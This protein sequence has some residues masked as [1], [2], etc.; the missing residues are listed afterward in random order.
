MRG[1]TQ[2]K[3]GFMS[4]NRSSWLLGSVLAGVMLVPACESMPDCGEVAAD[5]ANQ[6]SF[7]MNK[8]INGE[9]LDGVCAVSMEQYDSDLATLQA[10]CTGLLIQRR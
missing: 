2:N 10:S 6:F 8:C 3:R 5:M 4:I 7:L 1:A 9:G